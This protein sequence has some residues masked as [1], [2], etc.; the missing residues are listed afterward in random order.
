MALGSEPNGPE[1]ITG[2]LGLWL[3][4]TGPNLSRS[5]FRNTLANLKNW[6]AGI[7]PI[8]TVTPSDH[9]GGA[10][11]WLIKS[12]QMIDAPRGSNAEWESLWASLT[13]DAPRAEGRP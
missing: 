11:V 5:S 4:M 13:F 7:G 2:G 8:L 6:D 12:V 10:G 3:G 9:F 1:A